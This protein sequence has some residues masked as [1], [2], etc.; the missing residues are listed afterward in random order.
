MGES[1]GFQAL[2]VPEY[3]EAQFG[4]EANETAVLKAI[5]G[6]VC[7][8][9]SG[10]GTTGSNYFWGLCIMDKDGT[11]A[12]AF[13][14]AGMGDVDW[15]HVDCFGMQAT[16]S[17]ANAPIQRSEIAVKSSRR[18][19]S[20]D[21]IVICGQSPADA[22]TPTATIVGILRFYVVRDV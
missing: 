9:Q 10:A 17:S 2:L 1:A 18:L 3:W 15:L 8:Q 13:A 16:A 7:W 20:R 11:V 4:G 14:I 22:G 21:Q 5:R 19:R 6:A 12:P